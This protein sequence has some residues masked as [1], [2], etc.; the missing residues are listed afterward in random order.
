[1]SGNSLVSVYAVFAGPEEAERI[2]RAMVERRLAACV[3]LLGE[4]R[5]IYW[6]Q[7]SLEEATEQ[8]AIFKTTQEGADALVAAIASAHSYDT[9]AITAW[10]IA[11]VPE[12]YAAWVR[13]EVR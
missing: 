13:E 5:S 2:G 10:P 1:M 9:P 8:A 4:I 3:N 6:W 12:R 7:G 11:A